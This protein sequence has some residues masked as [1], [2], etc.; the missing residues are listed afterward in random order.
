MQ[1]ARRR[2]E[3]LFLMT[4]PTLESN[5]HPNEG[6]T[7]E[8]GTQREAAREED[9]K[10][11][12]SLRLLSSGLS[13]LHGACLLQT[14]RLT[15]CHGPRRALSGRRGAQRRYIH[16]SERFLPQL[17]PRPSLFVPGLFLALLSPRSAPCGGRLS[18]LQRAWSSTRHGRLRCAVG[19][20]PRHVGG[21]CRPI[22]RPS[23]I[24]AHLG[25]LSG[26]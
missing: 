16:K 3:R 4:Q 17:F 1:S 23:R 5:E 18:R 6:E 13:N 2:E 22:T 11:R 26:F 12:C 8:G 24:F 10:A 15:F 9:A 21:V 7:R 20:A 19:S 14:H 25:H